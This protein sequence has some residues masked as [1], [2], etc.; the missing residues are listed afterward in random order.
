MTARPEIWRADTGRA[1][2]VS[3]R[4]E[5][6]ETVVPLDMAAEDSFFVVFR[7]RPRRQR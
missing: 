4:I 2:P 3:Y 6:G 7:N 5:G 1:E